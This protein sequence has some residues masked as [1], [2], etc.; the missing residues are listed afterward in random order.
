MQQN[1]L[2]NSVIDFFLKMDGSTMGGPLFVTFSDIYMVK[3]KKVFVIS[4]TF[5]WRLVDGIDKKRKKE[6]NALF[7]RLNKYYRNAELTIELISRH[8]NYQ[9]L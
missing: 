8:Q 9:H 5:Y 3:M 4:F 7:Y 6:D 1:V 2:S